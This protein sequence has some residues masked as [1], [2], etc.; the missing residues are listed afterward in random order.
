MRLL[1]THPTGTAADVIGELFCMV[2][3]QS[4][5]YT[6]K[7][8]LDTNMDM[9]I[10]A[11]WDTILSM[12]AGYGASL[13]KFNHPEDAMRDDHIVIYFQGE[14][15]SQLTDADLQQSALMRENKEPLPTDPRQAVASTLGY[16]SELY[17]IT[18]I[19]GAFKI[20]DPMCTGLVLVGSGCDDAT[21][22]IIDE[23]MWREIDARS[24]DS[25]ETGPA[26]HSV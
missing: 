22:D 7:L 14:Q 21:Q 9:E 3:N 2:A 24:S 6:N 8:D 11:S 17:R 5:Q 23:A 4:Y 18:S 19:V 16:V 10:I 25:V 1:I 20:D 13:F 12:P 15:F 26:E